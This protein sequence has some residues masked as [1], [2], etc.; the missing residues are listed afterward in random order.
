MKV[1]NIQPLAWKNPQPAISEVTGMSFSYGVSGISSRLFLPRILQESAV[2]YSSAPA[3]SGGSSARFPDNLNLIIIAIC[4]QL[5]LH[6]LVR[7][8]PVWEETKLQGRWQGGDAGWG[9]VPEGNLRRI[10]VLWVVPKRNGV[11]LRIHQLW[12]V[13]AGCWMFKEESSPDVVSELH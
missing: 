12:F 7:S 5:C 11:K 2:N 13:I 1:F 10:A 6:S 9:A 4:C 8:A 3:Q